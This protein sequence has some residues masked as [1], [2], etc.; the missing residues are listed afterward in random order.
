MYH[1]FC[2]FVNL[3]ITQHINNSFS[4]DVNIVMWDT[5]AYG[6]GDLFND[7]WKAFTDYEIIHL[8]SYDSQ[9]EGKIRVTFLARSTEYRRILNQNEQR[10]AVRL[11]KRRWQ[12]LVVLF[13]GRAG[14]GCV[15]QRDEIEISEQKVIHNN[16]VTFG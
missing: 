1:H 12:H 2:D 13:D 9:R 8:K 6:Y 3:Y 5:S 11:C 15:A 7:T 4:T 10:S 16:S 14:F